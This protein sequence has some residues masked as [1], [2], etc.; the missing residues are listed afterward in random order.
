M[1]AKGTISNGNETNPQASSWISIP[2][3]SLDTIKLCYW[4]IHGWSSK[5]IGDKLC[6]EEFLGKVLN[7]DIVALAELHSEKQLSLP[8]FINIKQ[9]I[10]TKSHKGPK[11][12]GG[13]A[14][15]IKNKYEDMI[16]P[17]PNKNPDS[18]WVK[19]KKEKCGEIGDIFIG[20]FYVSPGNKRSAQKDFYTS[21]NEEIDSFKQKGI[22]LVQGDL[23][24][25]VGHEP[26]F[27]EF[28]KY[29]DLNEVSITE[30]SDDPVDNN[31]MDYQPR[32]SEDKKINPRGRD[33]LD[34]C[35]VNDLLIANGRIAGD[36]FGKFTSHQYN[37]SA[38]ND[39][40]L[41]SIDFL[42]RISKFTVGDYTPWLSDHCPIYREA[43]SREARA[44]RSLLLHAK[45]N[46]Y[47]EKNT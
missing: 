15:F 9:K 18:I 36:I 7:Y 32:N 10:R 13:I 6:D 29:L 26:D 19:I 31:I 24:A 20:S 47:E 27:I 11:I 17:I 5:I 34:L 42:H 25:R 12:S 22:V 46:I 37:G 23:N 14:I 43:S 41:T 1:V 38:V 39:Y 33:L 35:K 40:L 45:I 4:N 28:D 2:P 3:A 44:Q 30:S 16:E 21:L 8:G